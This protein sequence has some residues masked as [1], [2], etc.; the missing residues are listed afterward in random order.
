MSEQELRA[1]LRIAEDTLQRLIVFD[2]GGELM[3]WQSA[4]RKHKTEPYIGCPFC[5]DQFVPAARLAELEADNKRLRELLSHWPFPPDTKPSPASL[6]WAIQALGYYRE[7]RVKR[8]RKLA[9]QSNSSFNVNQ[10]ARDVLACIDEAM[11][12]LKG[13]R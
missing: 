13:Y 7:S 6:T 9:S 10:Q 4:H 1:R 5:H 12:E 11:A 2:G 8:F 3:S